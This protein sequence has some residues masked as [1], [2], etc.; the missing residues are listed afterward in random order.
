[1]YIFINVGYRIY[2]SVSQYNISY[3]YEIEFIFEFLGIMVEW[4]GVRIALRRLNC[5]M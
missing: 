5:I 4:M 3:F 1:M 2:I